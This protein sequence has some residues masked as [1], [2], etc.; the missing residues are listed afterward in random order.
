M[1]YSAIGN[2]TISAVIDSHTDLCANTNDMLVIYIVFDC[3][4]HDAVALMENYTAPLLPQAEC[5]S[6][7]F[8]S[9]SCNEHFGFTLLFE[10]GVL[11]ILPLALLL[12]LIHARRCRFYQ[13]IA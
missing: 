4:I 12:L 2:D 7:T 8:C 9:G 10:Q 11:S 13:N 6:D 1:G 3:V 5:I